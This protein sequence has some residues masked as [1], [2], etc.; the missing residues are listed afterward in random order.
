MVKM[1]AFAALFHIQVVFWTCI[2]VGFALEVPNI[3]SGWRK[4]QP[5]I[6]VFVDPLDDYGATS[7]VRTTC[8]SLGLRVVNMWSPQVSLKLLS[9]LEQSGETTMEL[10]GVSVDINDIIDG[11]YTAPL[12]YESNDVEHRGDTSTSSESPNKDD[13]Y[14]YATDQAMAWLTHQ[15]INVTEVLGVICESDVGLRTAE[16]FAAS[17]LL[18]TANS[19]CEVGFQHDFR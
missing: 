12:L 9:Y 17:L 19:R 5:N 18:P 10:A 1:L 11:T 16:E 15:E 7:E 3:I 2:S 13:R 8:A 6:V 14:A 4:H